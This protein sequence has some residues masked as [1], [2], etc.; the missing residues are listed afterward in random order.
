M[1]KLLFFSVVGTVF[2]WRAAAQSGDTQGVAMQLSAKTS[3]YD[4]VAVLN[5]I[6][7][8][9]YEEAIVYL[10]PILQ[11][12]SGNTGLLGYAGY[13]YYMTEDYSSAGACYR[14]LLAI[15]LNNI[16]ALHYLLLM[17]MTE[18][19]A[20]SLEYATR[21]VRLQKDRAPW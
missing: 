4:R 14:R 10:A 6:Q 21:L 11:A 9:E 19:P 3:L 12:D 20:E 2:V 17:D 15:G 16:P 1:K 8:Q 5:Y 18:H 13:S 7:N